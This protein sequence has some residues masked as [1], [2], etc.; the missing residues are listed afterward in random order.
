IYS[1][2]KLVNKKNAVYLSVVQIG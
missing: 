1:S 2:H